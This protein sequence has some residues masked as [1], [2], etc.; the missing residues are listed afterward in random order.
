VD[1][2]FRMF[3]SRSEHR[4]RLR[5]GNADLRLAAHGHRVGLVS[6]ERLQAVDARR[7]A[8]ASEM[9]RLRTHGLAHHLR[10]PEVS[11]SSMAPMDPHRPDLPANVGEEVEVELKYEGYIAQ[12]DRA[13]ERLAE[14]WDGWAIPA[15]MEFSGI[16]GLSAEAAEKLTRTKPATVGQARRIPGLTPAAISLLLIHLR[17]A[18]ASPSE[19][20]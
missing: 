15:S 7:R 3:T 12:A 2:P 17:R 10:R 13:A 9:E 8:I 14:A 1:E 16:R 4:L 5:E 6:G 20:V 19:G 11:Y 18:Q